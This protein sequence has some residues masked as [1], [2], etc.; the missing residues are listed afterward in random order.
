MNCLNY[1]RSNKKINGS[2]NLQTSKEPLTVL[3]HKAILL[4]FVTSN[5][6]TDMKI[7]YESRQK[8]LIKSQEHFL[9]Q[10]N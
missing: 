9:N 2:K 10:Q 7:A 5:T 1:K 4:R 8:E 3:L 6:V